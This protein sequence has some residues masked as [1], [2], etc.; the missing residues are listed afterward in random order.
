MTTDNQTKLPFYSALVMEM[1]GA[2]QAY[3]I[4]QGEK[5][6]EPQNG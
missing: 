1:W 4:A 6:L 3:K 5:C 2:L